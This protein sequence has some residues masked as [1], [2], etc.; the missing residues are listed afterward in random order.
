MDKTKEQ[1]WTFLIAKSMLLSQFGC[2]CSVVTVSLVVT[3]WLPQFGCH[4][5][6]DCHC[7]F[8]CHSL[9]ATAKEHIE[10]WMQK[11]F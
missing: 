2:H 4:C 1:P 3:V 9:V 6:F 8:G 10:G 5:E 11:G 7:E